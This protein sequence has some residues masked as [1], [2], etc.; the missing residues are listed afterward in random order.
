MDRT[1]EFSFCVRRRRSLMLRRCE[2]RSH[3]TR[4]IYSNNNIWEKI[5]KK[6]NKYEAK[7]GIKSLKEMQIWRCLESESGDD[8]SECVDAPFADLI[9]SCS[10]HRCF[11][12]Q[13]N[14]INGF[15]KFSIGKHLC[16]KFCGRYQSAFRVITT[17][18]VSRLV[19][20]VKRQNLFLI[21]D[22]TSD[23]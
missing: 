22:L 17:A 7:D 23:P 21:R 6:L 16:V 18:W 14:D 20:S 15:V 9:R 12:L 10:L 5:K 8:L 1:V 11:R 3:C 4:A 13:F 19:M 2:W